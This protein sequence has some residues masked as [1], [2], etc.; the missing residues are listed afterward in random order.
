MRH[1]VKIV[2]SAIL[3]L[4]VLPI[5][6]HGDQSAYADNV[7]GTWGS[8]SRTLDTK[9][10][11]TISGSGDMDGFNSGYTQAWRAY[12]DRIA[13]TQQHAARVYDTVQRSRGQRFTH[14]QNGAFG[15]GKQRSRNAKTGSAEADPVAFKM[16]DDYTRSPPMKTARAF[17]ASPQITKSA[18][19]PCSMEPISSARP[20]SRAGRSVA[21]VIASS[22]GMP[23]EIALSMS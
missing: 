15:A 3:L 8:L 5:L 7:S 22:R 21:A 18:S 19:L 2:F 4:A 16:I 23:K 13:D 9:G 12:Y 6:P 14:K 17:R 20:I 10:T 1:S 11:L